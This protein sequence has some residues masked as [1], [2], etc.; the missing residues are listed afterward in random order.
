MDSSP[1]FRLP[2]M[3]CCEKQT[4]FC[5]QSRNRDT[6]THTHTH[7]RGRARAR[8]RTHARTLSL[9]LSLSLSHHVALLTGTWWNARP[10]THARTHA[11]M[12][13]TPPT[14]HSH[15]HAICNT[16]LT[17]TW[18]NAR[19]QTENTQDFLSSLSLSLFFCQARRRDSYDLDTAEKPGF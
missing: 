16:V 14:L 15:T 12:A 11:R 8:A 9:S 18:R 10:H 2:E 3:I 13:R 19:C 7:A 17:R 1:A 5:R 6:H 4:L